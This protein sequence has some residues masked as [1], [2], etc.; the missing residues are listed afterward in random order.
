MAANGVH[1][2]SDISKYKHF[3][4][5]L[6]SGIG[7]TYR[8]ALKKDQKSLKGDI[9]KEVL[10]KS[11]EAIAAAIIKTRN[12]GMTLTSVVLALDDIEK[13][14]KIFYLV[15]EH[16][17]QNKSGIQQTKKAVWRRL[18][19]QMDAAVLDPYVYLVDQVEIAIKKG[20]GFSYLF[21][22]IPVLIL[23]KR[24]EL[25]V[26][27]GLRNNYLARTQKDG[28]GARG[29]TTEHQRWSKD[30]WAIFLEKFQIEYSDLGRF[31][32][33][34]DLLASRCIL[35]IL[36]PEASSFKWLPDI[37]TIEKSK[38]RKPPRRIAS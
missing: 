14:T 29:W 30:Q 17:I 7:S 23:R 9:P 28:G 34:E 33:L 32:G 16:Q 19:V 22:M 4:S 35:H 1:T 6:Q 8:M 21:S 31:K 20:R 27:Y 25:T 2:Q 11:P 5:C 3:I 36:Y 12:S 37:K 38:S 26:Y 13:S 10:K 24:K 15:A 18:K